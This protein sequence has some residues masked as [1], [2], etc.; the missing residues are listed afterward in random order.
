M[1][2]VNLSAF[3]RILEEQQ[4]IAGMGAPFINISSNY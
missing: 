3:S 4:M 1:E 2:I